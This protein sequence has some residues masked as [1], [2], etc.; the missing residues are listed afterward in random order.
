MNVRV[1]TSGY[2]Y[3]PW[4]GSFYPEDLKSADML[5]Y[6]AEHF[7]TVEINN[8][9]Y[10]MPS[11]TTIEHWAAETPAS[12]SFALKAPRRLS[13]EKRL[14]DAE[15]AAYFFSTSA[16]LAERLGPTLFQLP[17]F[18]R[19]D[20]GR[21]SD[22][23]AKVPEGR[24]VAF[25]FRHATWFDDEVYGA[26]RAKGAALCL[27]D[28]DETPVSRLVA[29]ADWGY[30]RLRRVAYDDAA[31]DTWAQRVRDQ[32]WKEAWVFFKHEEAGTGPKLARQLIER[33]G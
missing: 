17:P 13:H 31:L 32:P 27:A 12:F 15:A 2:S 8:T 1:G 18:F 5:R 23:L 11:A 20:V 26:L 3:T 16:L 19:K 33:L 9:F 25:E 4:K 10:R 21:L 6:Y 28:T 14:Q 29:T 24:R 22:F 7:P 30:L